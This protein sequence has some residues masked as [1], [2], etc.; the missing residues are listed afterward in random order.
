MVKIVVGSGFRPSLAIF[1]VATDH[2]WTKFC[3]QG[4]WRNVSRRCGIGI[5]FEDVRRVTWVVL[6]SKI[7][8]Q[9]LF[10]TQNLFSTIF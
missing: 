1:S 2:I 8:L 6:G 3:L 9:G 10:W 7:L 4:V 5:S